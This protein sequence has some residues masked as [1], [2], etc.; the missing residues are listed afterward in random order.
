MFIVYTVKLTSGYW[1]TI[2]P[3]AAIKLE[4]LEI[5]KVSPGTMLSPADIAVG[6][7]IEILKWPIWWTGSSAYSPPIA[8]SV[9]LSRSTAS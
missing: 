6:L 2:S 4:L 3:K 7:H 1:L 9:G 5:I 8:S